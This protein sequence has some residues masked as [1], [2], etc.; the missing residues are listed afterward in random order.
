MPNPNVLVVEDDEA[1][2]RLLIDYL[3][4][5]RAIDVDGARDGVE[6]LHRLVTGHYDV[7]ILDLMMP[8]MSGVDLLDSL[9]ALTT[10]PSVRSLDR[11]PAVLI[12]TSFASAALP[13]DLIVQRCPSV[14]YGIF[15]KPLDM[16]KV[17]ASVGTCLGAH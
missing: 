8:K 10:D 13:D 11:P 9:A 12:I 5:S 14:V 1:A 16:K 6:A 7:M 17:A 15:R 2:R 4:L 3:R